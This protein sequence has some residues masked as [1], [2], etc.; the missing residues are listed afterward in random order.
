MFGDAIADARPQ[1]D[2]AIGIRPVDSSP[3]R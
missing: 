3:D 2:P 1:V